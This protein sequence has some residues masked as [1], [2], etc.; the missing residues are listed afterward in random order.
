MLLIAV[1]FVVI[2]VVFV[3]FHPPLVFNSSGLTEV[4]GAA[5]VM[6]FGV[7]G[8]PAIIYQLVKP[9]RLTVDD[10]GFAMTSPFKRFAIERTWTECSPFDVRQ[11][12]ATRA[13]QLVV[14][15]TQRT[16]K[17][18]LRAFSRRMTGG[19]DESITP[20]YGGLSAKQL[21]TLLNAYRD[22]ALQRQG[23]P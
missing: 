3:I 15:S 19:G 2:G 21:A 13:N 7:L 6:F 9:Q 16:D 4:V 23:L 11:L 17:A 10:D 8:I 14:W 20:G 1:V 5:A 12:T 18:S 22:R